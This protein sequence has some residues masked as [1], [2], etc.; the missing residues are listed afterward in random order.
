M[1]TDSDAKLWSYRCPTV[2]R[3]SA[4]CTLETDPSDYCCKVAV[5]CQTTTSAPGQ[6][7]PSPTKPPSK[8]PS[9][10][11]SKNSKISFFNA[12]PIK[13]LS[14]WTCNHC[15][16]F[17]KALAIIYV[18]PFITNSIDFYPCQPKTSVWQCLHC[19]CSFL[20][21]QRSPIHPG[22]DLARWLLHH[23]QIWWRWQQHLQLLWQVSV[24]KWRI[25]SFRREVLWY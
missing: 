25:F 4:G 10:S 22:P 23:L 15:Q 17:H 8:W 13:P 3:L 14:K 5:C 20:C 1:H 6:P 24:Y 7:T 18:D 12:P 9:M 2:P 16:K 19:T 11:L 21:V